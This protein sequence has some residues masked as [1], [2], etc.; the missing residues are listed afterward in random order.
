MSEE[1]TKE[2]REGLEISFQG[3]SRQLLIA[4]EKIEKY[5][6]K[7]IRDD[8]QIDGNL[9]NITYSVYCLLK[10]F[11]IKGE[12]NEPLIEKYEEM[13]TDKYQK[14]RFKELEYIHEHLQE[15]VFHEHYFNE[16]K[17]LLI[18]KD[19][20]VLELKVLFEDFKKSIENFKKS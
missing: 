19:L 3:I 16:V 10:L 11:G 17:D 13:Q 1:I 2:V 15:Q 6:A 5:R 14:E 4:I 18:E 9:L 20:H 7:A 8:R 12:Y